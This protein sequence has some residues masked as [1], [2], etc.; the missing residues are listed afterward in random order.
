M[1]RCLI[2]LLRPPSPAH[3]QRGKDCYDCLAA[4][5]SWASGREVTPE[6]AR[7]CFPVAPH[8]RVQAP[9][10]N[11][12]AVRALGLH[13]LH[14]RLPLSAA[15]V[16]AG[17]RDGAAGVPPPL[18][19]PPCKLAVQ[20]LPCAVGAPAAAPVRPP[21]GRRAS[22]AAE[23][24]PRQP[25]RS[26]KRPHA[27]KGSPFDPSAAPPRRRQP[28]SVN[29][30]ASSGTPAE[31][32][33]APRIA[34]CVGPAFAVREGRIQ[35]P[36]GWAP[37]DVLPGP[38]EDA[39]AV[40]ARN[41]LP[42]YAHIRQ[43]VWVSRPR[44]KRHQRDE[45]PICNC[46]PPVITPAMLAA[47]EAA[48]AAPPPTTRAAA[49]A[50]TKAMEAMDVDAPTPAAL[51]TPAAA[52]D[53][54]ADDPPSAVATAVANAAFAPF[55]LVQGPVGLEGLAVRRLVAR[56]LAA[57]VAADEAQAAEAAAGG[58]VSAAAQAEVTPLPHP[59]L[60]AVAA[61]EANGSLERNGSG[62][63]SG[64]STGGGGRGMR[65]AMA[66]AA[67][68][69]MGD[70]GET[71][72][73]WGCGANCLNRLSFIH[74]DPRTCPCGERCSNQV[75]RWHA[76]LLSASDCTA[77]S[78]APD[79]SL[80]P[81]PLTPTPGS[82]LP[83]CPCR[84]WRFTSRPTRGGVCVRQHPSAAVPSLW[85]TLARWWMTARASAVHRRPRPAAS[86]TFT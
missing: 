47:R 43:N 77:L 63:L 56:M 12:E 42:T 38:G 21:A 28:A 66:A 7:D 6:Q 23:S 48:E 27:V 22:G 32:A 82:P 1:K 86:P 62:T 78:G 45:I 79:V 67:F 54:N 31:E 64:G 18:E 72:C 83:R 11:W 76:D 33:R 36:R 9:R 20:P 80:F 53:E 74:C 41:Q 19:P 2:F 59:A 8:G 57:A 84:P 5:F 10:V 37:P 13:P 58:G 51:P 4:I 29:A 85:S 24:G 60:A 17:Q 69:A 35:R 44:P 39:A 46:R 40:A 61:Q 16:A 68:A 55:I 30:S 15:Q 3:E 75:R 26:S 81:H 50:A 65:T 14:W 25:Q 71:A 70:E 34:P 52:N 49:A 73:W